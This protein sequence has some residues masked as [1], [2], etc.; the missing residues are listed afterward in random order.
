MKKKKFRIKLVGAVYSFELHRE[1]KYIYDLA[2]AVQYVY[3]LWPD[4]GWEVYDGEDA[5]TYT[6][7]GFVPCIY[8]ECIYY[9]AMKPNEARCLLCFKSNFAERTI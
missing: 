6:Q 2:E 4:C 5:V 9:H 3:E 1:G 8:P 7:K